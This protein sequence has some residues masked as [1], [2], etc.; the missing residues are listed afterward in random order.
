MDMSDIYVDEDFSSDDVFADPNYS[1]PKVS[2]KRSLEADEE[3]AVSAKRTCAVGQIGS[4]LLFTDNFYLD[5]EK[6]C[7]NK[8]W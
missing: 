8:C 7:L 1:L 3:A 4:K 2:R 5:V 6:V